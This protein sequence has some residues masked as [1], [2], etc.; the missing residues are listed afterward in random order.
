M[1]TW[2]CRGDERRACDAASSLMLLLVADARTVSQSLAIAVGDSRP[3]RS[4]RAAAARC[5]VDL[6]EGIIARLLVYH[7]LQDLR[8]KPVPSRQVQSNLN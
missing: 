7:V 2:T 4:C 5:K 6:S 1:G 3:W 8:G